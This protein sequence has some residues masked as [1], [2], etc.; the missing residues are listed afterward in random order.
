[1]YGHFSVKGHF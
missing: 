1:M